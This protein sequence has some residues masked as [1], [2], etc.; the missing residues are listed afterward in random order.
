MGVDFPASLGIRSKDNGTSSIVFESPRP[1]YR[2]SHFGLEAAP[3]LEL[4]SLKPLAT[5]LICNVHYLF[6]FT[7]REQLGY[8]NIFCQSFIL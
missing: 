1:A 3:V 5:Q 8:L 2:S 7:F 6:L 4:A